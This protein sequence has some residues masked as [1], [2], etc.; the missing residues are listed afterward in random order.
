LI[1]ALILYCVVHHYNRV[2]K[3]KIYAGVSALVVLFILLLLSAALPGCSEEIPPSLPEESEATDLLLAPG[4][5]LDQ[6][7]VIEEF[8]YP[9]HF[10]ISI[11]PYSGDRI[12]TWV[13]YSEGKALDFDNGQLFG[14]EDIEDQSEEY[15]P[16]DL[17]PEDFDSLMAPG[18]AEELLGEPIYT[19]DVE[20]SLMA[21]NTFIVFEKAVLL[22]RDD[23][24][25]GV[26]TQVSPPQLPSPQ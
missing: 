19:Y 26:D 21:E 25:I 5:S 1:Q 7:Q 8:G 11:D 23:Q 12:E 10:F 13:Y 4:L 18:E 24:L 15:P 3:R 22:Y 6:D 20:E 17:K 16:T 14:Q 2:M 9:D